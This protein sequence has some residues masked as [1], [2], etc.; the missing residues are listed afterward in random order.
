MPMSKKAACEN[1]YNKAMSKSGKRLLTARLHP[2]Y[3]VTY[4]PNT[5]V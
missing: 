4:L 2:S 5:K 1:F 3:S